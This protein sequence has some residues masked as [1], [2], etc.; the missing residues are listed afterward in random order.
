M[1]NMIKAI[2]AAVLLAGAGGAA[3]FST[4]KKD[5][6]AVVVPVKPAEK[7]APKAAEKPAEAPAPAEEPAAEAPKAAA[8]KAEVPAKKAAPAKA[9][10]KKAPEKKAA[11]A[12][13]APAKAAEKKAPAKKAPAKAAEKKAAPAKKAPAKK[14]PAKAPAKKA[15]P[16]KAGTRCNWETD[17]PLVLDYH[18][19]RWCKPVHDDQELFAMLVLESMQAGLS[20]SAILHKEAAF[21]KAFNDFDIAKVAGYKAKKIEQ[22]M[23][24]EK[25]VRNQRKIEAAVANAQA[26]RKVQEEFGSFDK[27]IWSFTDGKVVDHHL[28]KESDMPA[29]DALSERVAKDMK[30]RGFKFV[31][32]VI[33]YSYLQGIGVINDHIDACSF[34]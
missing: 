16:K 4:T 33:V 24:N 5:K 7:P 9:P 10:A 8:P 19:N 13:K 30:K 25:I 15:A 34:R 32:P 23:N 29:S 18:D 11:P 2:I 31:G 21:R 6:N 14:A 22:L 3:Y 17:D 26:V 20:W 27:Y 1:S 28:K 12:K